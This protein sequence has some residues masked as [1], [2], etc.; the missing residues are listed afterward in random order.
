[1]DGAGPAMGES[2]ATGSGR[3]F[4]PFVLEER[5]GVGGQGAVW[6][7]VQTEP[8]VR[9]VALKL[10]PVEAMFEPGLVEQFRKEAE[11]GGKLSGPSILPVLDFGMVQGRCYLTMPLVQ[12]FSLSEVLEQRRLHLKEKPPA[13]LHRL[14]IL[15]EPLY[16]REAVSVL[17]RITRALSSAHEGR[18]LHRDVKPSNILLDRAGGE[19]IYLSD[20]GLARDLDHS[21]TVHEGFQPGTPIYMAPERLLGK[22]GCE[23]ACVISSHSDRALW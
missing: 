1:M 8:F 7:A 15:A 3:R 12:G 5:I 23:D 18:I 4:G 11:R 20:F 6:R 16:Q 9:V 2:P 13:D 17:S 10:L 14:V 19:R 22:P 21:S